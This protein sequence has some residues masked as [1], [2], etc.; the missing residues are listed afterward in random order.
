LG[1]TA[2]VKAQPVPSPRG[3]NNS[4]IVSFPVKSL[5]SFLF[6]LHC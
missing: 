2:N 4:F 1:S 3:L 6:V 5:C